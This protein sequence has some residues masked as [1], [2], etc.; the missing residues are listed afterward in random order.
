MARN[1]PLDVVQPATNA[2]VDLRQ[3][4]EG[5]RHTRQ[6]RAELGRESRAAAPLDGLAE[7]PSPA[8]RADALAILHEQETSRLQSLIALR[9]ER[10]TTDPFA[11]LRGAAAV[12]AADLATRPN[13]GITVQLCGDAHVA[14]FGMFASPERRLVFDL[15]DFDETLPGPFEWDVKRLAASVV[16]AAQANGHKPKQARRA[17][18]SAARTYRLAMADLAEMPTLDVWFA[19]ADFETI[20][21][22]LKKTTL[23]KT[24]VKAGAKAGKRTGDSAVAKLTEMVDGRRRFRSDPPLLTRVSAKERD[25]VIDDLSRIYVD[26]LLTL[27]PDRLALLTRYSFVDVAHKVV[28]VG[29]VG[30]RAVVLLLESGDGEPLILQMKQAGPSVL[31][32]HLPASRFDQAGKRVV[33]GQRVMQAAGDPFLGWCTAK[34]KESVDFYVRQLRDLKG[35]IETAGL[36][37]DELRSY[38]NI[39]GG[40][41]ARAHARGGDASLISGYLGTGEEF[42]EAVA[43]WATGYAAIN[44]SD[45]EALAGTSASG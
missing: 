33:V 28:G 19:H 45:F 13:S 21:A 15:N 7:L 9:H 25:R 39:C 29:S 44:R 5:D 24:A 43:D 42:D 14:N 36:T 12:M 37:P 41:L 31:E 17:A 30:T 38:A 22:A 1:K 35:S 18:Q 32:S 11:F 20:L 8:Q 10:M 6:D 4:F 27:P 3:F 23:H 34:G 40:V 16:V 2:T 26:Y